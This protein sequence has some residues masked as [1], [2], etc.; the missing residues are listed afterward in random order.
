MGRMELAAVA[1]MLV[2]VTGELDGQTTGVAR[3]WQDTLT[4]PT[5][6]EGPPDP[7]PPFDFFHPARVNYPYTIRNNL[8]DRRAPR[9]WRTLVLENKYLRCVVLPDLGGHLYSCRDKLDGAE[10]FYANTSIK[11][12]QIGYRGAW[13]AL[14]VEF[15]FPVSHNWMTTSPVDFAV[16]NDADGSASVWIGNIDRVTGM[17]WR[18]Q[19]MLRPGRAVLEQHTTLFNR[20]DARHRFYWWTNAA[21]RVWD[22]SRIIYPMKYT[23]SHGFTDVD[24]WPVDRRGTDNSVVGNHLFG[25]VSRF[26]YGSREAWMA[27]YHPRTAAGVVHWSSPFDLPAK[28]IWSWGGDANGLRW[29]RALSDDSSAYAEIQRGLFRNQETYGFLQPREQVAFSEYWIP[30][31]GLDSVSAATRAAVVNVWRGHGDTLCIKLNVTRH[32]ADAV[33]T[34]GGVGATVDSEIVTLDPARTWVK[35]IPIPMHAAPLTFTLHSHE[36]TALLTHT[37]GVYDFTPDSLIHTGPQPQHTFPPAAQRS[38]GDALAFGELQEREGRLLVAFDAYADGLRRFPGSA[39]LTRALGRLAVLLKRYDVA[40]TDLDAVLAR[41]SNDYE[42]AYYLG[43]ARLGVGDTAGARRALETAQGY[44]PWRGA[45]TFHLAA[46]AAREGKGTEALA[47]L[48]RTVGESP[49]D[50][51][52]GGMEVAVLRHQGRAR[53]ARQD[54]TAWSK[55]DPTNSLLRYEAGRLALEGMEGDAGALWA[56]L[57]GDPDRIL[58]MVTDYV[59]FGFLDD[60]LDLLSR[61]Y[62]D[63]PSVVREPGMPSPSSSPLIAYY[64]GYVRQLMGRDGGPDD[65]LASHL[66]T[67]YVFP[68]RP[69]TFA[70]LAA[71]LTH[72][73][74]DATARFL[75]G[76]LYLSGGM[77]DSALSEW[78]RARRLNP[79]L[80]TLHRD[81][82]YTVLYAGGPLAR[83]ER[84]FREGMSVDAHNM[85]LYIGMDSTL[86]AQG[87]S[88]SDRADVLL[89]YPDHAAMPSALVY[90]TARTLAEG[91][92]FAQAEGLMAN[93]FYPSEEG[94]TNP[95]DVYLDVRVARARAAQEA[96]RCQEAMAIANAPIDRKAQLT[97]ADDELRAIAASPRIRQALAEVRAAC[98]R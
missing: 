15:N 96:D 39:P 54:L 33:I 2:V 45:A 77:A 98:R 87:R 86:R 50:V 53:E 90:L 68:N 17:Q 82:A 89:A 21:V 29:R 85:G 88:A 7:N 76:S 4:I 91:G 16:S 11:L 62:P 27:V 37:E 19:L 74:A 55:M 75:F 18:V 97:F 94:G 48:R 58:E 20:G 56:H 32:L 8:T 31:R 65:A 5:Y 34:L 84:L 57:A 46:L 61:T 92:R 78:E 40:T 95:R 70:V 52:A 1:I 22:D 79:R 10:V 67:T 26:A 59:R 43:L 93:R 63:G 83:A 80:P 49:W 44:G 69:E 72:D 42:A 64:R 66:P 81:M 23:A 71:A 28:K 41:V 30:I 36:G 24:T 38:E 9:V 12:T 13:A 60:A 47:L 73:S 6:L 35:S 14:G 51:R 25:P 3:A